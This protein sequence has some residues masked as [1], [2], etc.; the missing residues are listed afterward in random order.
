M[1]NAN[2]F[3]PGELH[4]QRKTGVE[5]QVANFAPR[6][7]MDNLDAQH[8]EFYPALPMLFVGSVDKSGQPWASVLAGDTGFIKIL[9]ENHVQVNSIPMSGDPLTKNLM[10]GGCLG[11]L[12]LEFETRR[13]NRMSATLEKINDNH[14]TVRVN[15]AFGN[16]PKYMQSRKIN[17]ISVKTNP[18]MENVVRRIDVLDKDLHKLISDADTFF[19]SSYYSGGE[20]SGADVSH[21]GGKPGFVKIKNEKTLGIEDYPGN[22]L[23]MTLGNLF[24]NPVAGLLFIDFSS[25]DTLQLAC[26][27]T[28]IETPNEKFARKIEFSLKYG[29][30]IQSALSIDSEFLSYSRFLE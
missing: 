10:H 4:Y 1:N 26:E 29:W 14:F 8:Q 19:I 25:G 15:Q 22:N 16:C 21:R 13:R 18:G 9:D 24:S 7:I 20:Q 28:V 17:R 3:H 12:G 11:F 30:F 6:L 27:V 23:F 5:Q 2:M